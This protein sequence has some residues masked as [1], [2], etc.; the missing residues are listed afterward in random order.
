MYKTVVNDKIKYLFCSDV[1]MMFQ[2]VAA[3]LAFCLNSVPLAVVFFSLYLCALLVLSDDLTFAIL[4]VCL[5]SAAL[6]R[7]YGSKPEDYFVYIPLAV[8]LAVCAVIRII[9]YPPVF[10]FGKLLLPSLAVAA[11][12]TAG[13]LFS[14]SAEDYFAPVTLYYTLSLGIGVTIACLAFYSYTRPSLPLPVAL[15]S[16]MNYLTLALILMIATQIAPFI[17]RSEYVWFFTWK[18]TLTTFLLLSCPFAFYVAAKENFGLKSA[19][20]FVLGCCGYAAAAMTYSRGGIFFGGAALAACVI[21]S[22]VYAEKRNRAVF[23]SIAVLGATAT[24][25]FIFTSGLSDVLLSEMRVSS[26]EAR[27]A[28]W[29]EALH[30][31]VSNPVF[32]AG[33]GFRGEFFNPQTGNMYWYHSTFFQIIGTTGLLGLAAYAYCYAVK[34]RI[35]FSSKRLFYIFFAVAFFGFEAYQSVDAGNFVPIPFVMLVTHMFVL[36]EAYG[37]CPAE[38]GDEPDKEVRIEKEKTRTL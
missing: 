29:K 27:V 10:R 21:L 15:T 33:V 2:V 30:N 4:P 35:L 3:T 36:A 7:Q 12:L 18:N 26:S 8:A 6:T 17:A 25:V 13:G 24:L 20:H 11:A 19:A 22:C 9:L 37:Y 16:Q 23:V 5:L 28:L 32:G 31:F 1:S 38:R 34:L 14:V